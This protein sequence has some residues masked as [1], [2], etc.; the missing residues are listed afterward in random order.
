MRSQ[1]TLVLILIFSLIQCDQVPTS[2]DDTPRLPNTGTPELAVEIEAFEFDILTED[3]YIS[4]EASSPAADLDVMASLKVS[5]QSITD[6]ILKDD[7]QAGDIQTNDGLY[8]ANWN[9]PDSLASYIDSLWV[10][11]VQVAH[12]DDVLTQSSSLQPERPVAPTI[13]SI[14]HSDTLTLPESGMII[15]TLTV[16]VFLPESRDLLREVSMMSL[17]PDSTYANSGNPIPLYDDGGSIV[18]YVIEGVALTSGDKLANDGIYSL[19][20]PLFDNAL[21]GRY[22]WTFN[23]RTWLGI[24]ADP[25]QDSLIVLPSSGLLKSTGNESPLPGVF[26]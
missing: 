18:F 22:E 14:S 10:L 17:K 5:G 12:G 24:E 1:L 23:A 19:L 25:V 7:G 16:E 3:F 4:I 15:D 13:V 8:N 21:S 2:L 11:E 26:Q 6:L 9:L 20:L